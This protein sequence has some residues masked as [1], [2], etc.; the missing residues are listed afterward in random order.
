MSAVRFCG[1]WGLYP[2]DILGPRGLS[3]LDE[4]T[5]KMVPAVFHAAY[6][7]ADGTRAVSLVNATDEERRCSLVFPNGPTRD[8]T[9]APREI[10]L[11]GWR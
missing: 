6:E 3:P 1:S 5:D 4:K 8:F 2:I 11:K 10:V 9:L 7:A